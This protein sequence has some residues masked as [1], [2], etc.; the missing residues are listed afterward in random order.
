MLSLYTVLDTKFSPAFRKGLA[1]LS[2]L[3]AFGAN[4]VSSAKP[5]LGA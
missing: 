5:V 1:K 3:R 2:V 4:C